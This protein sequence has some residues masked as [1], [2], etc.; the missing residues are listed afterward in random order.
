[1]IKSNWKNRATIYWVPVIMVILALPNFNFWGHFQPLEGIK[2]LFLTA[3]LIGFLE[4]KIFG[5][6]VTLSKDSLLYRATG[7][8]TFS[9]R[10]FQAKE[11][12]GYR[13]V[14]FDKSGRFR[15]AF[16]E[17]TVDGKKE[18]INIASFKGSDVQKIEEWLTKST[19]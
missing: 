7:F 5:Y 11:I 2:M 3:M 16:I 9:K 12:T 13:V 1:M 8:P 15:S 19:I 10:I 4:Y 17:L 14:F 18:F 6:Q